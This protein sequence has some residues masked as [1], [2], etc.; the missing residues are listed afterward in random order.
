MREIEEITVKFWR[1][2]RAKACET[3]LELAKGG[4]DG[5]GLVD[6][7]VLGIQAEELCRRV[8]E[9]HGFGVVLL[10]VVDLLL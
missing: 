10:G 7:G 6:R 9:R 5:Q 1:P 8:E 2:T 4:V 3:R